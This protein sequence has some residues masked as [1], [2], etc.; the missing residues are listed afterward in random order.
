V[1]TAANEVTCF[2]YAL[3]AGYICPS[4]ASAPVACGAGMQ[5]N[6]AATACQAAAGYYSAAPTVTTNAA[7]T[8]CAGNTLNIICP[9]GTFGSALQV[10]ALTGAVVCHATRQPNTA[11]TSCDAAPGYFGASVAA[12]TAATACPSGFT[13][14]GGS[15]S[16]DVTA[17]RVKCDIA[18]PAGCTGDYTFSTATQPL[19]TGCYYGNVASGLAATTNAWVPATSGAVSAGASVC[20]ACPPGQVSAG[21]TTGPAT[22]SDCVATTL[23]IA[24]A[25]CDA[26]N[27]NTVTA[28]FTGGVVQL[29]GAPTAED[30]VDANDEVLSNVLYAGTATCAVATANGA[31][32][33]TGFTADIGYKC[34]DANAVPVGSL[35]GAAAPTLSCQADGTMKAVFSGAN[36]PT[37]ANNQV[38]SADLAIV[39][40][41]ASLATGVPVKTDF[42]T[43]AVS[44]SAAGTCVVTAAN[45]VTC[46]GAHA[47][48]TIGRVFLRVGPERAGGSEERAPP[49]ATP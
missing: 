44:T 26:A 6:T 32:S 37:V 29:G 40:A 1:V 43:G 36:Y 33:C 34:A 19:T 47:S 23:V 16:V 15:A 38:S 20:T 25:V 12:V 49:P 22:T 30:V 9:A 5:S 31:F 3:T 13:S 21:W 48:G 10:A 27:T 42:K 24:T 8:T 7:G 11:F 14:V 45:E 18:T 39:N 35:T 17:C 2:G 28:S 46:F 41:L 4:G